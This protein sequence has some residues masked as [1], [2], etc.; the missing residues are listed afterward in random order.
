M[1]HAALDISGWIAHW[2]NWT[3][4]K[5][6][7]RFDGATLSYAQLER[8][9]GSV[10]AWLR[11]RDVS[12][13]DRVG[14]LGSNCPELLELLFAC[15][16]LGAIFVPLNI[17]MPSAELRVFVDAVR[18]SLLVA[19]RDLQ[20][21]AVDSMQER[22]RVKMFRAG[23]GFTGRVADRGSQTSAVDA[24]SP[25]LILFTSG[26]TG[27]PKGAT[28]THRNTT[29]SALNVVTALGLTAADEIVTTV[30]MFHTGGL[31]IHT[32]PGLFVGATVTIH[33]A[34]DPGLLL[35]EIQGR[36]ITLLACVPAMTFALAA[37]PAWTK[38]DL[39]S[40]RCVHTGSTVVTRRAIEPWQAKGVSI[41]QGY[42]GTE[43]TPTATTMPPDS[44]PEAAFWAGKPTLYTQMR[45]VDDA[46]R[47]VAAGTPGEVWFSG[48][49]VAQ[50]YWENDQATREAFR[51][52]WFRTGDLGL[53]DDDGC[54]HVVGRIK[55]VIIVGGSNVD[56]RDLEA[57]LES[58]AAIKE[59]AVV[60]RP[61]DELGEVPVACIVPTDGRSITSEEVLAL[62]ERRLAA[63]KHPRGVIV[64]GALPRNWHGKIDR[65]ALRELAA[66]LPRKVR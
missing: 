56:P 22:D 35:E 53:I 63:Y 38:A 49:A 14:Y 19:E 12:P 27:R 6:A 41:V 55:D 1:Q 66:E 16:R 42:G 28:F 51:D 58:C 30:P 44:P 43:A 46:G 4:D 25:V 40:L 24:A 17:R 26:T 64:L 37:H 29:F 32:L 34:F 36:R 47:D 10:A 8:D 60:G 21:A 2:A 54:L 31:F 5:A 48:P 33:R 9:V 7:L 52:G 18:P 57:V 65:A 3:P 50:G 45:V 11:A 62:F 59:A 61:D 15:A 39:S 23:G 20:A 13:G